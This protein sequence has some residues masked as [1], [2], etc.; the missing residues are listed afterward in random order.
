MTDLSPMLEHFVQ[1]AF[2]VAEQQ[3]QEK[4]H[5]V[6]QATLLAEDDEGSLLAPILSTMDITES[7]GGRRVLPTIIQGVWG[8]LLKERPS[9]K[10]LAISLLLDGWT[11]K[12]TEAVANS[13]VEGNYVPPSQKP[14]GQE[15]IIVQLNLPDGVKVYTWPYVRMGEEVLFSG[16]PEEVQKS[17]AVYPGLWPL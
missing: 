16:K 13:I 3:F 10:L 15:T 5:V 12:V 4:R 8:M 14:D 17:G 1:S 6:P 7:R 9:L 2:R 11:E